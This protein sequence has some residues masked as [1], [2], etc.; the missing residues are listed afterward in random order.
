MPF[1]IDGHN[2]IPNICGL[3]LAQIDDEYSLIDILDRYFRIERKKA[4]VYFDKAAPGNQNTLQRGFLHVHFTRPPK[5]ADEAILN[6]V[7]DLGRSASN[8]TIVTS[9][10]KVRD[11][12]KRMGARL[13]SSAEFAKKLKSNSNSSDV[14]ECEQT[15]NVN[16]W[17]NEFGE[18]S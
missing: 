1:I 16:Y 4:I 15:D 8:Y 6:A 11:S 5:S 14:N 18:N 10:Q 7:R 3:N 9:D 2:L 17:L 12:A 13:L